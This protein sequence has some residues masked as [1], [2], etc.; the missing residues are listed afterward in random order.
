[1]SDNNAA[2]Y[3]AQN[4]YRALAVVVRSLEHSQ[5]VDIEAWRVAIQKMEELQ[6]WLSRAVQGS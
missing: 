6:L 4:A 2:R 1:M 3:E 5:H